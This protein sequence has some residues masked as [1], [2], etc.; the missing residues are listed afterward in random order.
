MFT[1]DGGTPMVWSAR[2][3]RTRD[4][5]GRA[6]RRLYDLKNPD[7]VKLARVIGFDGWRVERNEELEAA[8]LEF[9]GNSVPATGLAG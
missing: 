4:E 7:S 2:F 8:V 5:G 1:A 6:A 3:R 9:L